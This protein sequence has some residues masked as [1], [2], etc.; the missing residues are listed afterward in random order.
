MKLFK[1]KGEI[2]RVFGSF[3][4][5]DMG[6]AQKYLFSLKFTINFCKN[7]SHDPHRSNFWIDFEL[8][9]RLTLLK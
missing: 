4:H 8:S 1:K 6:G 5:E 9:G 7:I 3:L 2:P